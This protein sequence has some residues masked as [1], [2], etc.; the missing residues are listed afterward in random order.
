MKEM[1]IG[2]W[3]LGVWGFGAKPQ[4]QTPDATPTHP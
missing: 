2:D 4:T 1:G 3:G